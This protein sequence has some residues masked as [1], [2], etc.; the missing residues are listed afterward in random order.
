MRPS[1]TMVELYWSWS[2]RHLL[3]TPDLQ[4]YFQPA[5]APTQ[6]MAAVFSLRLTVLF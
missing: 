3:I 2:V 1:E 5:L 6:Q 4:L